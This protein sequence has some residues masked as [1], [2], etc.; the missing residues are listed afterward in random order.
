MATI[1]YSL[2]SRPRILPSHA[3]AVSP[4]HADV[5]S[6]SH[7]PAVSPSYTPPPS[8]P[9]TPAVSPLYT[10][11]DSHFTGCPATRK[12]RRQAVDPSSDDAGNGSGSGSTSAGVHHV[13]R[14]PFLCGPSHVADDNG[15]VLVQA[16]GLYERDDDAR[17]AIASV[18]LG[19]L[20]VH[21]VPLPRL[22]RSGRRH[23]LPSASSSSSIPVS[24]NTIHYNSHWVDELVHDGGLA[25]EKT[26]FTTDGMTITST[27]T[28]VV[29]T[30]NLVSSENTANG[31][32]VPQ[33]ARFSNIAYE[34]FLD[35]LRRRCGPGPHRR[36]PDVQ[37]AAVAAGVLGAAYT[38]KNGSMSSHGRGGYCLGLL[39]ARARCL[40]L[41]VWRP[42]IVQ[43]AQDRHRLVLRPHA[44]FRPRQQAHAPL[45]APAPTA[46]SSLLPTQTHPPDAPP[47][48]YRD[49]ECGRASASSGIR[50]LRPRRV[51]P[52]H[53][54]RLAL[55]VD[56][57]APGR[58]PR[59]SV[60]AL[61]TSVDILR[62]QSPLPEP[63]FSWVPKIR[64]PVGPLRTGWD[65][66][67]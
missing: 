22:P 52:A 41:V 64:G 47:S 39:R 30:G 55:R 13:L 19:L 12:W 14:A 50:H 31:N 36:H 38:S 63:A 51:Q 25:V 67:R 4:S 2:A 56:C 60:Y 37:M 24:C 29:P 16:V 44:Q 48:L 59:Q 3:P 57:A 7:A 65:C 66:T 8:R 27:F 54:D 28:T 35:V 32:I 1:S 15:T 6:P 10:Q 58:V 9:R 11:R 49:K 21:R 61:A 46:P 40:R 34:P 5:L 17:L 62:P 23:R 53:D 26:T 18:R 33:P 20:L 43:R 45:I 42:R